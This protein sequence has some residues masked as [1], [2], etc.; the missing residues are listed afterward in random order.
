V[1]RDIKAKKGVNGFYAGSLPNFTRMV[2]K[3]VYRY[4]LMI[5]LPHFYEQKVVGP[6]RRKLSKLLAGF[7]IALIESFITCPIERAKVFFMTEEVAQRGGI[8]RLLA[9]KG[10][11][12]GLFKELFRGFL[13][14]LTRQSVAWIS[15]L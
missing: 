2:L 7:S 3:N 12:G 4:P 8:K 6:E 1:F 10:A 5:S 13:P 9:L 14:L 11:E 15:F